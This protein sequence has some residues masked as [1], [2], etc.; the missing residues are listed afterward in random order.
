MQIYVFLYESSQT[1]DVQAN[2]YLDG[3][4]LLANDISFL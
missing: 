3:I 1:I 2:I 4:D